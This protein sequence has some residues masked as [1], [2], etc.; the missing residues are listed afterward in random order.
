MKKQQVHRAA[1]P[2]STPQKFR[3]QVA[4]PKAA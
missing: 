3:G 2:L 4:D 1:L